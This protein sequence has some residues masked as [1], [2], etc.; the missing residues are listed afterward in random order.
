MQARNAVRPGLKGGNYNLLIDSGMWEV[1]RERYNIVVDR[2][3]G[4]AGSGVG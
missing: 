3:G 1:V 4:R 2:S